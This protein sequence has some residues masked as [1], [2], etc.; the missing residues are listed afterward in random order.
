MGDLGQVVANCHKRLAAGGICRLGNTRLVKLW[1]TVQPKGI[2]THRGCNMRACKGWGAARSGGDST[3]GDRGSRRVVLV[4]HA[5]DRVDQLLV[6]GD[7]CDL[8][9][10]LLYVAVDGAVAHDALVGI[11]FVHELVA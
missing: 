5:V 3:E 10:Q 11:D 9:A 8:L 7:G 4:T 2:R 1:K 6:G